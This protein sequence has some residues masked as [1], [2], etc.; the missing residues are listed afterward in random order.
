[1]LSYDLKGL[2]HDYMPLYGAIKVNFP[3]WKH[4]TENTWL[5][6]TEKTAKEIFAAI[7]SGFSLKPFSDSYL[8]A[9]V[10]KENME[11]FIPSSAWNWVKDE[12]SIP[13]NN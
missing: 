8:I 7:S 3:E 9:E 11:G 10:N 6:R 2:S 13:E 1:M 5:L 4:V 12:E